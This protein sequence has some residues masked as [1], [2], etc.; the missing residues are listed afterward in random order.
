MTN[1]AIIDK[2]VIVGVGLIGGSF[3]LA[4]RS[5]GLVKRITGVGR[6]LQNLQQAAALG[7]IDEIAGDM[8]QALQHADLVFLAMPVGQ[9]AATMEQIA[10]YLHAN[11]I[12]TDA[13][14]TKQNVI[15]A[16][17]RYL[18]LQSRRNFVPGHPIA[19]A[20]QS[21]VTAAQTDLYHGKHVILTPLPETDAHAVECIHQL[22][23]ACGSLVSSMPADEHDR[24]LAAT[25]HLPHILAFALMNHLNHSTD[26]PGNL[27]RFA[28][29]GFRDFTRIAS[30]SPEMWRDICLA[31]REQLIRQLT[32]YQSELQQ[33]QSMLS[34]Y[35]SAAL[36]EAFALARTMREGWLQNK[37]DD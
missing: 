16:A 19:G 31:N 35:D 20:E 3:A 8:A 27:L 29:S 1:P 9:T 24:I 37:L 4:L 32:A 26:H 33:L 2:L 15:A 25:S 7:V 36:E 17:R 18:P 23:Q 30:S 14:S 21:G 5:A 13:G 10:P 12:V 28:G 11:T 22:W 6:S 34:N